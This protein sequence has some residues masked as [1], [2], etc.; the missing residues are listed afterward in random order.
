MI[1]CLMSGR[2][3][4]SDEPSFRRETGSPCAKASTTDTDLAAWSLRPLDSLAAQVPAGPE[5]A[6]PKPTIVHEFGLAN[7]E[8]RVGAVA[9]KEVPPELNH[10]FEQVRDRDCG[11][12]LHPVDPHPG[13][14]DFVVLEVVLQPR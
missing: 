7:R 12:H 2:L 5:M 8:R 3:G 1:Q 4:Y 11:W 9:S 10:D 13:A 6:A 14:N